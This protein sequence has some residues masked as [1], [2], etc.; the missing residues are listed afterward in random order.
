MSCPTLAVKKIDGKI[1]VDHKECSGA[2]VVMQ[3]LPFYAESGG[4]VTL[5]GKSIHTAIETTGFA[6][7]DQI[8]NYR[9]KPVKSSASFMTLFMRN[10]SIQILPSHRGF[11]STN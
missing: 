5:Q 8:F 11:Y 9:S 3:D 6:S 7:S 4:S 2:G 1:V 10:I